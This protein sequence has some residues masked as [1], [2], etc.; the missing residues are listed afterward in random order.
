MYDLWRV[1]FTRRSLREV[2]QTGLNAE[3]VTWIAPPAQGF[4]FLADPFGLERDGVLTVFVEAF[5]YRVKRGEIHFYQY[6]RQNRRVGQGVA[7]A[8]PFHLSYPSLI[9]DGGELYMLPEGYKSGGLTLYR[10]VRF[11]DRWEPVSRLLDV[12]AIDATLVRHEGK[13]WMFHALPGPADRAMRELH[14]HFADELLGPWTPHGANPVRTGFHTSRPGGSAF[15]S[16]GAVYL[17]VQD[18]RETYGHAIEMLRI[19]GLTATDFRATSV[20]RFIADGLLDGF[21]DG[22]HTLSGGGDATFLDVK[23]IRRSPGEGGV[24]LLYKLRRLLR[25]NGPRRHA[26]AF[27][28]AD[29]GEV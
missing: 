7:L 6:D 12:P 22:L 14:V 8:E 10:C 2:A 17:P 26:R 13:W 9:E 25:L 1:G 19:D 18:C 28:L 23:S 3:S 15:V 11:P 24:R 16:D 20:R 4:Q 27:D 29:A 21:G 5:D